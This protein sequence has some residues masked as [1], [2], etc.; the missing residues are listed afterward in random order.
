VIILAL[1]RPDEPPRIPRDDE[2]L[3]EADLLAVTGTPEAMAAAEA[4]LRVRQE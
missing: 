3:E 1:L 2:P 4:K